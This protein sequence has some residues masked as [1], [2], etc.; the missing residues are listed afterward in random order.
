MDC[1]DRTNVVQSALARTVLNLQLMRL[2]VQF[3][4]EDGFAKYEDF[5]VVFNDG[6]VFHFSMI[7]EC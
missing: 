5:E 1:L 7:Y 2:G 6:N 4:P 3:H